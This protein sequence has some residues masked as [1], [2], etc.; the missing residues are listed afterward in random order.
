MVEAMGVSY[1][2]WSYAWWSAGSTLLL[3]LPAFFLLDA[4]L[5]RLAKRHAKLLHKTPP[6]SPNSHYNHHNTHNHNHIHLSNSL[7]H[8]THHLAV[9][10]VN[11]TELSGAKGHRRSH[12]RNNSNEHIQS[13]WIID[14]CEEPRARAVAV[15]KV[16][17]LIYHAVTVILVPILQ[18]CGIDWWVPF[19][20]LE[21]AS[22]Y[23]PLPRSPPPLFH[24]V[25]MRYLGTHRTRVHKNSASYSPLLVS[26]TVPN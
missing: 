4:F 18:Y 7:H 1:D 2:G 6:S 13:H 21:F 14:N 17:N 20:G 26:V 25:F 9:P 19:L 3:F 23:P 5:A 10:P 8:N 15:H 12:S 11:F 24:F 16:V 22:M